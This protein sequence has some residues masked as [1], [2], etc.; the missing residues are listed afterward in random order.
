MSAV[1]QACFL[2]IRLLTLGAGSEVALYAASCFLNPTGISSFLISQ[3][4]ILRIQAGNQLLATVPHEE[5]ARV[6]P[7]LEAVTLSFKQVLYH[8]VYQ[9]IPLPNARRAVIGAASKLL[10]AGLI[11]YNR[12]NITILN[13]KG[14][15]SHACECYSIVKQEFD[16]LPSYR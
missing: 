2:E 16:C 1:C 7:D 11:H 12:G 8:S 15:E 14:L 4:S 3:S 9:V 13:H 6:L 5:N 10:R